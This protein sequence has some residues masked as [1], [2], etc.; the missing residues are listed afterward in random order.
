[1]D[2]KF[3]VSTNWALW[4]AL[5]F[6]GAG[7]AFAYLDDRL[8]IFLTVFLCFLP[9]IIVKTTLNGFYDIQ[10][11]ALVFAYMR[12]S[13]MVVTQKIPLSNISDIQVTKNYVTIVHTEGVSRNHLTQAGAFA[14]AVR[15]QL[16]AIQIVK[17]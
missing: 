6:G 14:A 2:N 1:M 10:P 15:A 16:P 3:Y 12:H 5:G 9:A 7:L 11:D 13:Q 4:L 8:T 17:I